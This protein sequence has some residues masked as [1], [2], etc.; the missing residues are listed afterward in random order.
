[1]LKRTH[2]EGYWVKQDCLY[3]YSP[4]YFIPIQSALPQT[5]L[6][7]N[8]LLRRL[9]ITNL[10]TFLV[11]VSSAACGTRH[12]N[13]KRRHNLNTHM[14]AG[15]TPIIRLLATSKIRH[16]VLPEDGPIGLKH[17]GEK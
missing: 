1:M 2:A 7:K 17:V 11:D 16:I 12:V 6:G 13:K 9:D 3:K 10:A 15:T 5:S 4:I 8:F 14:H